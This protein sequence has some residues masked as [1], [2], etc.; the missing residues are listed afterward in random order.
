MKKYILTM[1]MVLTLGLA[2][3]CGGAEKKD[4]AEQKT[5]VGAI[6]D[7]TTDYFTFE[8]ED[9]TAYQFPLNENNS[10]DFSEINVGEKIEL[11]Y[12]GEF[13]EGADFEG[14]VVGAVAVE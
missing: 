4:T 8:S 11:T 5:V 12:E 14:S 7:I 10:V 1:A 2:A 13:S 3:G 9:G 6:T